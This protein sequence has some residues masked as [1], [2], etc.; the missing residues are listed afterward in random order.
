MGLKSLICKVCH[1]YYHRIC[2]KNS[3]QSD[4]CGLSACLDAEAANVTD[5]ERMPAIEMTEEDQPE[6]GDA[7]SEPQR[8]VAQN[9]QGARRRGRTRK[10]ANVQW[11]DLLI[12]ANNILDQEVESMYDDTVAIKSKQ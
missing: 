2:S 4:T 5:T 7:A 3:D 8:H 12:P 1:G 11:Q 9:N 10:D 6:P